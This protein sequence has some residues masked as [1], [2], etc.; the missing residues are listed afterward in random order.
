MTHYV[1]EITNQKTGESRL[2]SATTETCIEADSLAHKECKENETY[3]CIEYEDAD[4]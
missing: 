1:Y 3:D 4:W 2:F